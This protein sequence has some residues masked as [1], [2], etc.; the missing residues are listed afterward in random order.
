LVL[1]GG[2]SANQFLRDYI[3][4]FLKENLK[5][6]ELFIPKKKYCTDNAAMI[7]LL[8]YYKIKTNE[9]KIKF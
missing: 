7:G 1:G 4:K 3:K 5:N 2:V 6:V 8:T 9:I